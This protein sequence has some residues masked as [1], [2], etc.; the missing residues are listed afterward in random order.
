MPKRYNWLFKQK[1]YEKANYIQATENTELFSLF[2]VY[3][4]YNWYFKKREREGVF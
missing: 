2:G 1:S 4:W 3:N